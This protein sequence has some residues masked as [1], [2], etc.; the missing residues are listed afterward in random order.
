M[1]A[2][3]DTPASQATPRRR[4]VAAP[5][6]LLWCLLGLTALALGIAGTVLPLLPTTPFILLAA[7]AFAQSSPRLHHWL[8]THR[9]F[10]PLIANWQQHGAISRRTKQISVAVMIGAFALSVA[11]GV[12]PLLLGIQAVVL[13]GAATFVLT[14]PD[15]PDG[16]DDSATGV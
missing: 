15:G 6:R 10:G 9:R 3:N 16:Q 8:T 11:L 2:A 13:V 1:A 12:K 5:V 7:F 14:R 4:G